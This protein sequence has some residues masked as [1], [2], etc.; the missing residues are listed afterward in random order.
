MDTIYD[1]I[2]IVD[3]IDNYVICYI[4]NFL[5]DKSKRLFLSINHYFNNLQPD[6]YYYELYDYKMVGHLTYYTNFKRVK[7]T[8]RDSFIP[9]GITDLIFENFTPEISTGTI[10]D[11]VQKITFNCD[12]NK[13]IQKEYFPS[14]L[15]YLKFGSAFDQIIKDN[16]PDGLETL[17]LSY[18]FNQSIQAALPSTLKNLELYNISDISD[19]LPSGLE[20]LVINN[21]NLNGDICKHLPLGLKSLTIN[22]YNYV[23]ISGNLPETLEFLNLTLQQSQLRDNIIP[24]NVKHLV[25]DGSYNEK[26]IKHIPSSVIKLELFSDDSFDISGL[27]SSI[28]YLRLSNE[29]DEDVNG[30]IP[31]NLKELIFG[32]SFNSSIQN[33]LPKNL[34]R[35]TFGDLFNQEICAEDMPMSLEYVKFGDNFN[36]NINNRLT[37]LANLTSLIFG[38]NFDKDIQGLPNS[39]THLVF[40]RKFNR[41][42]LGLIPNN[43]THLTLGKCFSQKIQGAI[44]DSVTHLSINNKFYERNKQHIRSDINI[45]LTY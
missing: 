45:T 17:I 23:E 22:Y 5:D 7:Y 37:K 26:I 29:F 36:Q 33:A 43:V 8:A 1:D 13:P 11:S 20:K 35:I 28:E 27:A 25:L 21:H 40:G 18:G 34:K 30:R 44:P 42:I 24:P 32:R 31:V 38:G 3:V 10:P 4:A 14:G 16:L 9:K 15:R 12:F 6:L 19:C 39:L 2:N 41:K